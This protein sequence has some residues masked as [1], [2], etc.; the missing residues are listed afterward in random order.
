LVIQ[1]IADGGSILIENTGDQFASED[2]FITIST[3]NGTSSVTGKAA[4]L[5]GSG[6]SS[7]A[8]VFGGTVSISSSS[9]G[10]RLSANNNVVTITSGLQYAPTGKVTD[11]GTLTITP[12]VQPT[13]TAFRIACTF[14]CI[15]D[16]SETGVVD[17]QLAVVINE[18]GGPI[19]IP[20]ISGQ[21]N[22]AG[23]GITLYQQDVATFMYLGG[24][25]NIWVQTSLSDN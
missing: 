6:P 7:F 18:G 9:G 11:S 3:P 23:S 8:G 2:P 4:F 10:T 22:V 12:G 5:A 13:R 20:D 24:N 17:G 16:L 15:L 21:Q 19:T 14:G 1:N 25:Q